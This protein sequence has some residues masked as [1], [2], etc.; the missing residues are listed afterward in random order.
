MQLEKAKDLLTGSFLRVKEVVGL[1]D[2]RDLSHFVRD[3]KK[4]YGKTPSQARKKLRGN[5]IV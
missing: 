1:V 3:F 5:L 2:G 4:R